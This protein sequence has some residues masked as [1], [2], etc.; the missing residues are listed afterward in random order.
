MKFGKNK[1]KRAKQRDSRPQVRMVQLNWL[2]LVS[3]LAELNPQGSQQN[4][5]A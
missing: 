5:Q 3:Y 4:S 2:I 1:N